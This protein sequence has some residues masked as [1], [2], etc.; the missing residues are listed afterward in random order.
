MTA[1]AVR[2][3]VA[4]D[5]GGRMFDIWRAGYVR[6]SLS[7]V[8][9]SRG[10]R[11]DEVVWLPPCGSFRYVADPFGIVRDR[12]LTVFVEAFDYRVRRGEIHFYQFDNTDRLLH[13]GV[14][15]ASDVHLSYP[16]LIEADGA[17]Y[18]LPEAHKS[19]R[20]TLY[21]CTRFPDEWEPV[22]CL[23][24][25]P[26]IDAT[27]V[28]YDGQWW[29]F[30]ALPGPADRA[31]REL[32][33]ACAPTLNGPWTAHPANPVRTG[34][35]SARP[36]GSAFVHEGALHVPMQDCHAT[37]GAAISLLRIDVLTSDA[38]SAT[39]VLRLDPR[40]LLAGFADGFH[41]LS[42]QGDV[43]F[44]DVKSI[45][46]SRWEPWVRLWSKVRKLLGLNKPRRR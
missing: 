31:M 5:S 28:H 29:M 32:H 37:Y 22:E 17:L 38:F 11:P 3:A 6:R 43:T 46:R 1:Q 41:T 44:I 25:E 24:P 23:L 21:R 2:P 35:E 26:A 45:R 20:L 9:T 36:G 15:L 14:A 19:G 16:S 12:V 30:Y 33:V 34:F 8:A 4:R 39:P 7:S 13:R 18:L 42:G 40:G 10:V 27:V